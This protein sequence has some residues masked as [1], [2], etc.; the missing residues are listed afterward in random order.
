MIRFKFDENNRYDNGEDQKISFF[1][2]RVYRN[3]TDNSPLYVNLGGRLDLVLNSGA[4][5]WEN[6]YIYFEKEDLLADGSKQNHLDLQ[7][8]RQ[9]GSKLKDLF[10]K[11]RNVKNLSQNLF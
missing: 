4:Q 6:L 2:P 10:Q 3:M 7:Y 8:S 11:Y 5:K 1:E 9:W